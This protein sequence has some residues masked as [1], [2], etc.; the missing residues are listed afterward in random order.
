M[1]SI[2]SGSIRAVSR[3]QYSASVRS[4]PYC[5]WSLLPVYWL[6]PSA[7]AKASATTLAKANTAVKT[8]QAL[9]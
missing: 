7:E 5:A 9:A 8:A 1:A 2:A 6:G 3:Y 4:I